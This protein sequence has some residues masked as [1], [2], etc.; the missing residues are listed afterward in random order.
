[1]DAPLRKAPERSDAP[2]NGQPRPK[3]FV[4]YSR[5]DLAFAHELVAALDARGF[6]PFLDK[7]DIAP[8]EPWRE[9]LSALIAAAD[10]IV[11][12]VS[13]ASAASPVCEW[14]IAEGGR[15]GKRIIPVVCRDTAVETI[16]PGLARLNFIFARTQEERPSSLAALQSSL[17]QDLAWVREHTRLA[18]LAFRWDKNGRRPGQALRSPDLEAAERWLSSQPADASQP[19]ALHRDFVQASRR[20]AR[21]RQRA[22]VAGSLIVAA[23]ALGLAVFAELSRRQADDALQAAR[24]TANTLVVNLAAGLRD[25]VG[26][27]V[28]LVR[29]ILQPALGLQERLLASGGADPA[30]RLDESHAL[31]LMTSTLL[32]IGDTAEALRAAERSRA[33]AENLLRRH[34]EDARAQA[35][36]LEGWKSVV[37]AEDKSG[38]VGLAKAAAAQYVAAARAQGAEAELVQALL[39][40]AQVDY[41]DLA[42]SAAALAEAA[43][44]ARRVTGP[45]AARVLLQ[46]LIQ[47]STVQLRLHQPQAALAT[48]QEAYDLA[49]KGVADETDAVARRDLA[50]TFL[51]MAVTFLRLGASDAMTASVDEALRLF[52]ELAW[53]KQNYEAQDALAGGLFAAAGLRAVTG[54]QAISL[55]T[56]EE[57]IAVYRD[58]ARDGTHP[59]AR[60]HLADTLT[61]LARLRATM[62]DGAEPAVAELSEAM[63]LYGRDPAILSP[64]SQAIFKAGQE[65][66]Q[67]LRKPA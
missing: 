9:R 35:Q 32:R 52:R 11:F 39:M 19:T 51:G 34:P 21:G 47:Q 29:A 42:Q 17:H 26:M 45:D 15:L 50:R 12:L 64:E 18:E 58:L 6:Q 46:V 31:A 59:A 7:S 14:E 8:G 33:I 2:G 67:K 1:M 41:A 54:R 44:I 22:W 24:G 43:P 53:D 48:V 40:S 23:V 13:P 38:H 63:G 55:A 25:K 37:L 27:P 20:A 28:T 65:L 10:T 4:S 66:L 3:I 16:P 62:P 60:L 61:M 30:L 49:M 57:C 5:S 36:L 56:F